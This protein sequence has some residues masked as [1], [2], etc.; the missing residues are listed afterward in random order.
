MEAD[1]RRAAW[2]LLSTALLFVPLLVAMFWLSPLDNPWS[3][4]LA[5]PAGGLL[6][7]FFAL[8]HDCGH[9]SFFTS[10]AA[11]EWAG[12]FISVL[13][14]TPYDHWRR[15]HAVHHA[16]SGNLDRRG[17]GD[18]ETMTVAEYMALTPGGKWRYRIMRHPIVA[19]VIGPPLYFLILQRGA[20]MSN[21]N[22]RESL[23][24]IM[25]HNGALLLFYGVLSWFLGFA[26]VVAVFL[27]IALVGSW[28]GGWLFFVQHQFEETLWENADKWDV[29]LAALKG[30]SHLQMP[31]VLNW[32]TCD[33]GLHH[34]HHLSSRIPNYRLRA[35]MAASQGLQDIAPKLSLWQGLRSIN[36]G[37]WDEAAFKLISFS[38]FNRRHAVT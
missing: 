19:L 17:I 20:F 22:L 6:T 1:N 12:Q 29:K 9:G 8:Q 15:S 23:P 3:L 35:C 21:M 38:E 27:P 24:G 2:Q 7:R 25:L 31:A 14:F 5:I 28:I 10:K 11:N 18:V 13:T 32:M 37:L 33:I 26:N 30:S 16:G 34:I 36:L 4:L